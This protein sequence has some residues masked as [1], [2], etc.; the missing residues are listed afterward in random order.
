LVSHIPTKVES[1][2][3]FPFAKPDIA[4]PPPPTVTV[5]GPPTATEETHKTPPA[6]PPPPTS[7]LPPLDPP[8]T[9]V[10]CTLLVPGCVV[11][12]V[13]PVEVVSVTLHFPKEASLI[14]PIIPPFDEAEGLAIS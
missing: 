1:V 3:A 6:P 9:I 14:L 12:V 11:I 4:A 8:A 7:A 13:E 10:A 2:P 5:K